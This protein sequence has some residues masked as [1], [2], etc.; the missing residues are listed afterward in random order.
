MAVIKGHDMGVELLKELGVEVDDAVGF[1]LHCYADEP[2]ILEV[3]LFP[4]EKALKKGVAIVKKFIL[5]KNV[6]FKEERWI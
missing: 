5:E 6:E 1:S 2:V 4:D 3:K